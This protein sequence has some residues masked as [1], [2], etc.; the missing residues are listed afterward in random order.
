MIPGLIKANRK[1]DERTDEQ[2]APE[3]GEAM[4]APSRTPLWTAAALGAAVALAVPMALTTG[5]PPAGAAG[6]GAVSSFPAGSGAFAVATADLNEDGGIDAAVAVQGDSSIYTLLGDGAGRFA[7]ATLRT[8]G[9]PAGADP[10]DIVACDINRDL[11]ADLVVADYGS[12]ALAVLLG[13]GDGTFEPLSRFDTGTHPVVLACADF[14]GDARPDLVTSTLGGGAL[15]YLGKG[16]G[17]F[18]APVGPFFAGGG[19]AIDVGDI[20]PPGGDGKLDFA[21]VLDDSVFTLAGK[22]DG[23]F[24]PS[25]R[26]RPQQGVTISDVAIG[27]FDADGRNDIAAAVPASTVVYVWFASPDGFGQ[28]V[29]QSLV[30]QQPGAGWLAVADVDQDGAQ[31]L[32]VTKGSVALVGVLLNTGT[33]RMEH[34]V[35]EVQTATTALGVV[36]ADVNRDRAPDLLVAQRTSGLGVLLGDV[37]THDGYWSVASDGGIFTFGDARFYGSTGDKRLA[38]PI[39]GMATTP[40]RK[41]YWFVAQDGGVFSFGNAGFYGSTGDKS[42]AKPIVG[43]AATPTGKGY[44]FVAQDGGIFAFGDARFY[45]SMGDKKLAR[46][47]VGMAATPSGK[48]YWFVAQDG[49]IFSFGDAVFYGSMGGK[50]LAKPIVGMA[51]TPTGKGYWFVASDG[52]VFSFGDAVFHGSTGDRKLARPIVG[53]TATRSGQGYWFVASDGGVFSFGDAPF[54]GSSGTRKLNQPIVGLAGL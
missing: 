17:T 36:V 13:H 2:S 44:W 40:L 53:M 51:A 11:H 9:G 24:Q 35:P 38:R 49:G 21:V 3:Q 19:T 47:I 41:G 29:E 16:D 46:P 18:I 31:D 43:M 50:K 7:P 25:V 34:L 15:L 26:N 30:A 33:P 52:G 14:N 48:G 22:G 37:V 5:A 28:P 39:V 27:D 12:S 4:K 10:R 1:R 6:F 45:G 32:V 54:K 42:L 20:E 8:V 23:T